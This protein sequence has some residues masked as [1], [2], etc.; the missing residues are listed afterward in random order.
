[1]LKAFY[2]KQRI[3]S[4]G[5]HIKLA[6]SESNELFFLAYKNIILDVDYIDQYMKMLNILIN[7]SEMNHNRKYYDFVRN[8]YVVYDRTN[9]F[10][11]ITPSSDN[12]IILF[13]RNYLFRKLNNA[14][15][16]LLSDAC[17]LQDIFMCFRCNLISAVLSYVSP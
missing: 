17:L 6:S 10:P 13:F 16:F 9:A 7:T 4:A 15:R 12:I 2:S 1:M 8:P 11:T 3:V 14:L 5:D